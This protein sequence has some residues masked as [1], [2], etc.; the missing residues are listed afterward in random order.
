[1]KTY[2]HEITVRFYEVDRAGIAFFGRVFEYCHVAYEE[3]M[4]DLGLPDVF[5]DEGWGM[6][7]VHVNSNFSHPMRLGERITVALQVTACG[8]KSITFDFKLRGSEDGI[9]RAAVQHVHAFVELATLRPRPFPDS[10][11]EALT[12]EGLIGAE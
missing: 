7:L 4:I 12:R 1:M 11:R 10:L 6:P 2:E 9:H 5:T 3:L 8:G